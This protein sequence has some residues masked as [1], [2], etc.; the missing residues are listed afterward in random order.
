MVRTEKFKSAIATETI[1]FR[2]AA[3]NMEAKLKHLEFLQLTINRMAGN[4]FY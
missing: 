2:H 3:N 1:R 4:S